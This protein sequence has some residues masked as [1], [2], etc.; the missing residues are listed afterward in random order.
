MVMSDYYNFLHRLNAYREKMEMT[1]EEMAQMFGVHQSHYGRFETGER[2]ISFSSLKQ[3]EENGGD[4]FQLLTGCERVSGPAGSYLKECTTVE[5]KAKLLGLLIWAVECGSWMDRRP[6]D[7]AARG[8]RKC[9]RL[10]ELKEGRYSIWEGIRKLEDLTQV[11]MAELL[12][13]EVKKYRR[14]EKKDKEPDVELLC[15]LF[16]KL[17]YSPQ[18]FFDVEKFYVDE[19]NFYW[20]LLKPETKT[21]VE[22]MIDAALEKITVCEKR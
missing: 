10:M 11:Q 21:F 22:Q 6:Q 3:F 2:V 15:T 14:I 12:D 9:M 5:G 7:E 18:I 19:L 16:D 4:L 17:Q 13:I 1:Q 20:N 8:L